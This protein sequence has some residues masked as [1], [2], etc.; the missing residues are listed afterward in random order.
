MGWKIPRLTDT[1]VWHICIVV[2]MLTVSDHLNVTKHASYSR[3]VEWPENFYRNV[4][5]LCVFFLFRCE[6]RPQSH[7]QLSLTSALPPY[8]ACSLLPYRTVR[9]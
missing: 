5:P 2:V 7:D 4:L 6:S 8:G 3:V 1:T 9:A